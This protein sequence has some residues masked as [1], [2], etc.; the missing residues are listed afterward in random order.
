[1][2]SALE[3]AGIFAICA[4]LTGALLLNRCRPRNRR[5]GS[6]LPATFWGHLR[7]FSRTSATSRTG[8]RDTARAEG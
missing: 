5:R 3:T 6:R 1:M 8:L 2:E 7:Q 4:S